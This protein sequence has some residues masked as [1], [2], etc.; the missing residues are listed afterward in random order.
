MEIDAAAQA[1]AAL[2]QPL[3]LQILQLLAAASPGG[4]TPGELAAELSAAPA[5]LSFHLRQL[6]QAGL[7]HAERRG[8]QLIYRADAGYLQEVLGFLASECGAGMPGPAV[9][10]PR[11]H[12]LF[13]CSRNSARSQMAEALLRQLSGERFRISSAGLQPD[14]IHPLTLEVLQE[15]GADLDPL[16]AEGL[17]TYLGQ[18][19][20]DHAVVVC[21]QA[22]RNC[23]G[24]LPMC[25]ERLYWPFPDPV[26]EV[27][28]ET[29]EQQLQRFR[30]V[31]EAI[32]TRLQAWLAS[33]PA[34][35]PR[36]G[37]G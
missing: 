24:I 34:E 13:L 11:R 9:T 8:R 37:Q 25:E 22:D 28:G 16:R 3:R 2:G 19:R 4:G 6:K 27:V 5:T 15:V 12:V 18:G 33:L 29:K 10:D 1:L 14:V 17:E 31:R 36:A 35:Q 30:E 20:I 26:R 7:I 23:P 21:A 32:R